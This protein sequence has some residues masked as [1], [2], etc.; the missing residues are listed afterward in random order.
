LFL[1][2]QGLHPI[3]A[4]TGGGQKSGALAAFFHVAMDVAIYQKT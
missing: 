3:L 4:E 2:L 1:D